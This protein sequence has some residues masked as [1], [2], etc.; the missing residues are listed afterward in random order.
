MAADW[1]ANLGLKTGMCVIFS[2]DSMPSRLKSIARLDKCGFPYIRVGSDGV[3]SFFFIQY[4]FLVNKNKNRWVN[5]AKK[6]GQ[7][8][9]LL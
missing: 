7:I 1:L 3:F 5:L 6:C 9:F 2:G 4:N 8:K